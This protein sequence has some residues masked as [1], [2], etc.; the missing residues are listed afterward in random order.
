MSDFVDF[1]IETLSHNGAVSSRRMFG[2]HGLY[3]DGLM[4][5]LIAD[6][7]LYLK[8]D[9]SSAE[10]FDREGLAHFEF[11]KNGKLVKMSYRMAPEVIF[12]DPEHAA[13]WTRIAY[14]A[15]LRSQKRK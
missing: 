9:K 1:A 2:G 11:P 7:I 13:K 12:D 10:E 6:D 4:F 8:V 14:D 15:A 5:A 3:K